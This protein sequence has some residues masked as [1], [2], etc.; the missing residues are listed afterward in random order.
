MNNL[1]R[2]GWRP[3]ALLT[4]YE[5]LGLKR[6]AR[7]EE[8]TIAQFVGLFNFFRAFVFGGRSS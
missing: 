1:R 7:P 4:A 3:D 6:T 8:L 2:S 5:E